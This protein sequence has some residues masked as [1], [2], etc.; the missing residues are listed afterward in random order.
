MKKSFLII[1]T[2]L[3]LLLLAGC[4]GGESD[5]VGT[6]TP[7]VGTTT[8]SP[9]VE[10]H[11]ISWFDANGQKITVTEVEEGEIPAYS[12]SVTDTAEWDYSFEGWSLTA[13]GEALSSIPSA[14]EDAAYYAVV[15]RVKRRYTVSFE[16][17]G[18]SAVPSQTVE[19][20]AT[21]SEPA[22]PTYDGRRFMGWFSDK[23]LLTP[24]D[25]STPITGN[26]TYY[27]LANEMVDLVAYL[28]A[29]LTGY[30][31]SPYSYIPATMRPDYTN[32][33]ISAN[34]VID[35]YSSFV[36]V[37]AI[38]SHGFG[39]QWNMV[40]QN[41][42]QSQI[43]YNVLSVVEALT[44]TSIVAFNNYFD[45]NPAKTAHHVFMS[46][47]Y[48]VTIDFDGRVMSYVLD[49]TTTVPVIG[50]QTAQIALALDT[51]S[52]ERSTRIQ[53]GDANALKYTVTEDSFEFAIKYL[54]VRRAY[55]S[56]TRAA[57]GTVIGHIYEYLSAAGAAEIGSAADF[58][59]T[60]DY[61]TAVGNKAN[62]MVG[63]T[64]YISETYNARTGRLVGYEVQEKLSALTYNTLWFDLDMFTGLNSIKYS[65]KVGKNPAAFF[66]NGASAA[67]Q[68]ENLGLSFGLKA[69]SRRFDIEFRTQYFYTYDPQKDEYVEI[70]AQVPMLM[71]QEEVYDSLV[72]D[73]ARKND[74]T[75]TPTVSTKDLNKLLA[76]YDTLIPLFAENKDAVSSDLIVT[77]I[78]TKITF[79]AND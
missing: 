29:L 5:P 43:F 53:L 40:L 77:H 7:P 39:E 50:T 64:G 17:N 74:V 38:P 61:V 4:G 9:A 11:L 48:N 22:D 26:V 36:N 14:S 51:E 31:V 25:W 69:G 70:A 68:T 21:A 55:F 10:K 6:T 75:I 13:G 76:D 8:P 73:V 57:N 42:Q 18:G 34:N 30:S 33:L 65:E 41:I 45:Q 56:I 66:I 54:G 52:G 78:G 49:F 19:Y 1:L 67:W 16:S 47:I 79:A 15:S 12:F 44:S 28:E 20:G 27:A 63:F 46:G 59:I 37:S 60:D 58:Y 2:L 24:V 3:L 35:N 72:T 32:N 62:G 71:V 23:T